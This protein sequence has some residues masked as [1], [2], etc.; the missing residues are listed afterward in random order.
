MSDHDAAGADAGRLDYDD[1]V[2]RLSPEVR[3]Q[4]QMMYDR[5]TELTDAWREQR[6]RAEAAEAELA[7]ER[8]R[9][10]PLRVRIK[11][12]NERADRAQK[13]ARREAW[14]HWFRVFRP[15]NE[16]MATER[17]LEAAER[18]RDA[19]VA[20]LGELREA[21]IDRLDVVAQLAHA[22]GRGHAG[23]LWTA[24]QHPACVETRAVLAGGDG[25]VGD[26]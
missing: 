23:A 2:E 10:A 12:A 24:C 18:E 13:E 20:A 15:L 4:F 8:E 11:A 7:A 26:A 9:N 1:W 22:D 21:V 3:A 19:A 14:E 25:E 17:K 5:N 16:A 6:E